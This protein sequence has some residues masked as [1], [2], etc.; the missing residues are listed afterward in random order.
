MYGCAAERHARKVGLGET[1]DTASMRWVRIQGVGKFLQSSGVGNN[2]L[3]VGGVGPLGDNGEEGG[4][5]TH[6]VP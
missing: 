3:W 1:G 2:I 6:W 5:D 4:R